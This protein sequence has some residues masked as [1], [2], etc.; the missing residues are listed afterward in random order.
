[1]N[2]MQIFYKKN[3][4]LTTIVLEVIRD[5]SI[6][7]NDLER[8]IRNLLENNLKKDN[9]YNSKK[10]WIFRKISDRIT[11]NYNYGKDIPKEIH[12]HVYQGPKEKLD[13]ILT[14]CDNQKPKIDFTNGI[15]N[16]LKEK[17]GKMRDKNIQELLNL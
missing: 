2:N 1:M 9:R 11:L 17:Y 4:D 13:K 16:N 12:L 14:F 8:G 5:D 3:E 15:G 6:L 10:G 7:C